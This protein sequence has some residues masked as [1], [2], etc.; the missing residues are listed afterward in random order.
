MARSGTPDILREIVEVKR[1]E[2]ER[3]RSEAPISQLEARI[4]AQ[5][6]PL[7][8]AG[9][10]LGESVRVIAEVKKASPARGLLRP[11]F[12]PTALARVYVEHGAVAISVLTN[13]DHFQGSIDHMAAVHGVANHRGVPVLRKEF[14]FDPYQVYEARAY[15]ADAILLIV[16]MLTPRQISALSDL[17]RS[18]WMQCLIEVHNEEEL[19]LALDAG[20]EIVGINNRDLH[21][22]TTDLGVTERLA[23]MVPSGKIVVSES[24]ISERKDVLRV[25]HAGAHAVLV[26][27]ALITAKDVGAKLRELL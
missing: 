27:E 21:T 11:D 14:I 13:A 2:V 3:L 1:T 19:H 16:A 10:L 6:L 12:D 15:G 20:A 9:A 22:F 23:P 7:N 17:A 25:K 5:P 26:G 18:F 8:L 24:G 4:A